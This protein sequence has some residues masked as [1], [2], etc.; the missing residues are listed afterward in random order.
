MADLVADRLVENEQL[1]EQESRQ[2]QP[3]PEDTPE[4]VI[5]DVAEKMG[6]AHLKPKQLEAISA[7]VSGRDVF[8]ALPTGYGKSIIFGLLP[9]LFNRIK[10]NKI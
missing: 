7:F 1:A 8:V 4:R 6:I 3:L 5:L 9:A 2:Q 10:G